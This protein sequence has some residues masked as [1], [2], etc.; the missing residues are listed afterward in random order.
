MK[1]NNKKIIQQVS[2]FLSET[3]PLIMIEEFN[4]KHPVQG[5]NNGIWWRM[6]SWMEKM[7]AGYVAE[8]CNSCGKPVAKPNTITESVA[9]EFCKDPEIL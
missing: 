8:P 2:Q 4:K 5:V 1:N 9:C 3:D 6:N 7:P